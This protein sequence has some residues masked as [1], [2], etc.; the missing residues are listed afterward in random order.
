[1]GWAG[2]KIQNTLRGKQVKRGRERP[3]HLVF[4]LASTVMVD[5]RFAWPH[6]DFL[7]VVQLGYK[8]LEEV[9]G[10]VTGSHSPWGSL[11]VVLGPQGEVSLVA[12]TELQGR[13]QDCVGCL[14]PWRRL[15]VQLAILDNGSET[16]EMLPLS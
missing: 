16:M 11:R 12:G 15:W 8:L 5:G 1:M 3:W 9:S 10:Q 14:P 7:V 2:H 6:R 4:S 13:F